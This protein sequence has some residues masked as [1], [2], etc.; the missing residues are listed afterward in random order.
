MPFF[1]ICVQR[2]IY[3]SAQLGRTRSDWHQL[4]QIVTLDDRIE[5][6]TANAYL[7]HTR[8]ERQNLLCESGNAARL[9]VSIVKIVERNI[10]L[11]DAGAPSALCAINA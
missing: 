6:H 8:H 5:S 4:I 9:V 7:A 10:E 11:I 2:K 3:A 1:E